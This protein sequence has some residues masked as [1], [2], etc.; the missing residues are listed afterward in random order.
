MQRFRTTAVMVKWER[1][2]ELLAR[3]PDRVGLFL[4]PLLEDGMV[5]NPLLWYVLDAQRYVA[6]KLLNVQDAAP[7]QLPLAGLAPPS[8]VDPQTP[9][10]SDERT[11][12]MADVLAER[13]FSHPRSQQYITLPK[14]DGA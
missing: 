9:L 6:L 8:R 2:A 13:V 5:P 10:F 14:C 7:V 3:Y 11:R 4:K 1:F 12:S